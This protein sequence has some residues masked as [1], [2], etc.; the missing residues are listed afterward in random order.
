MMNESPAAVFMR[1][2]AAFPKLVVAAVNGPAVGVAV[3]LL[4][5]V[6]MVYAVPDAT[7]W[8]PFLRMAI[9]PEYASSVLFPAVM[10]STARKRGCPPHVIT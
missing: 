3:T 9:V 5:H 4:C 10:V 2:I 8:T 7:F 1:A 6:D